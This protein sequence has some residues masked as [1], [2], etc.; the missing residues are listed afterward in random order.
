MAKKVLEKAPNDV[1][2]LERRAFAYKSLKKFKEAID[3]YSKVIEKTPKDLEAYRRRATAYV[4]AGDSQKA[5]SDYQTIL[6]IKPD[7]EAVSSR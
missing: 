1:A 6:K 5:A 4:Q 2:A 3:D 7:E